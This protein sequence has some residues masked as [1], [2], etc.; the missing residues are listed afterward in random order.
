MKSVGRNIEAPR[1]SFSIIKRQVPGGLDGPRRARN[2]CIFI[3]TRR[4]GSIEAPSRL[5]FD[6]PRRGYR[7]CVFVCRRR[8]GRVEAPS[9]LAKHMHFP[10][11]RRR[12]SIEAPSRPARPPCPT[13]PDPPKRPESLDMQGRKSITAICTSL[14]G[15]LSGT[16][17]RG[18]DPRPWADTLGLL[19]LNVVVE[20]MYV[21]FVKPTQFKLSFM[22]A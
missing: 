15:A 21:S 2:V 16:R 19:P 20:C 14:E 1:L 12:G 10:C 18:A 4:R 22:P 3:C 5:G 9:R 7:S 13:T 11:R 6:G 17:P 8:R